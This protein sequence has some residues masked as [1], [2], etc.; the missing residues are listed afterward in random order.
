[1]GGYSGKTFK[2]CFV[3]WSGGEQNHT[4]Q[5]PLHANTWRSLNPPVAVWVAWLKERHRSFV[6]FR[7]E[8]AVGQAGNGR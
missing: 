8:A 6:R 7:G 3:G 2:A 4:F 5:W 1:M